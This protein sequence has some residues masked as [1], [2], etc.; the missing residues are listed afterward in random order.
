MHLDIRVLRGEGW[1]LFHAAMRDFKLSTTTTSIDGHF[2]GVTVI[3]G[4]PIYP[5]PMK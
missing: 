3:V 4:H 2:E 5:A 1:S